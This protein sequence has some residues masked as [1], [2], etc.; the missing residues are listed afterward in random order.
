M[1]LAQV[2]RLWQSLAG[3]LAM[4]SLTLLFIQKATDSSLYF[5]QWLMWLNLP[6]L[7]LHE[8]E[9]Y[10]INPDGFKKFANND[11]FLATNPPQENF[12]VDDFMI[13]V[14]NLFAW[15]W[16][17]LGALLAQVYPWIGASF[18]IFQILINCL[19]HPLSFQFNSKGYNPGL[20]TTLLL[21]VPYITFSFWYIISHQVFTVTDWQLT[22]LLGVGL[23]ALLPLWSFTR[24]GRYAAESDLKPEGLGVGAV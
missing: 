10:V 24:L 17:L 23:S 14:V 15:T 2:N 7:F 8:Y 11:T 12:P 9:E 21:L 5:Y 19:S 4:L 13:L 22:V 6:L 20:A 18:L 16:G 1:K 3:I